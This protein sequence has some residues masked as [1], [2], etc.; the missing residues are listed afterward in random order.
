MQAETAILPHFLCQIAP[1]SRKDLR[2]RAA[3]ASLAAD[4]AAESSGA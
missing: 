2:R 3:M 4:F 1:N